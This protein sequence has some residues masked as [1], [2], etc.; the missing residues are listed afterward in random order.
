MT[1]VGTAAFSSQQST[2]SSLRLEEAGLALLALTTRQ[3]A[4]KVKVK[5]YKK[6]CRI[7]PTIDPL[8]LV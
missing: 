4:E 1:G 6:K 7:Q 3:T 8:A 2:F 5:I